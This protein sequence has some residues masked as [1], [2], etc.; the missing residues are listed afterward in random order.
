MGAFLFALFA[1][2]TLLVAAP[3]A[4]HA[5]T[6][7][8]AVLTNSSYVSAVNGSFGVT[9]YGGDAG[10]LAV[11]SQGDLFYIDEPYGYPNSPFIVEI[12][13]NGGAPFEVLVNL[14][15][16][17]NGITIDSQGN[18]WA[19]DQAG[20][21]DF[22]PYINGAFA[23]LG[24]DASTLTSC[25]L[26]MSTNTAPCTFPWNISTLGYYVQPNDIAIDAAG[27][28]YVY[29]KY[30]GQSQGQ[31]NRILVYSPVDGSLTYIVDGIPPDN[32]NAQIAVDSAGDSFM[33]NQTNVYETLASD[34][35]HTP[36]IIGSGLSSPSGVGVDAKNNLYITD[37]GNNRIVVIPQ[38]G[39]TYS[40]SNQYM[41]AETPNANNGPAIDGF[42]NVY[43]VGQY[44]NS[45]NKQS[46]GTVRF[47]ASAVGSPNTYAMNVAFNSSVT[48][49]SFTVL[50]SGAFSVSASQP[51]TGAC[52][53]GAY[54]AGQYCQVNVTYN[55]TAAG[56]Q[57]AE[58][59]AL[60]SSNAVLGTMALSGVGQAATLN[61]D[62]GTLSAIG[63]NWSAPSSVAVD[64]FG[65][66]YVTDSA[67]GK[68]YK[69]PGSGG[70][71]G[72]IVS[73]L[74]SPSAIVVDGGGN[75]YVAESTG[76]Y[77][78]ANNNG[79]YG[80]PSQIASGTS[81]KTGLAIDSAGVLYVADSGNS[82]VLRISPVY[83]GIPSQ[84]LVSGTFTA[85]VAVAVDGY[86]NVFVVDSG[87][88][89]EVAEGAS[90]ATTVTTG[91]SNGAGIGVDASGSLYVL[92]SGAK[93][94]TRIPS[95]NG[96]LT[97]ASKYTLG[98]L[99][100]SPS[101]MALDGA[102]DV[103]IVDTTDKSV[104]LL[105]RSTGSLAFASTN[106]GSTSGD[107]TAT[108]SDG[109]NQALVFNTPAFTGTTA[110][111]NLLDS[112]TCASGGTVNAGSTCSIVADF[113]PTA[114]GATSSTLTFSAN[115]AN[116]SSLVLAGTGVSTQATTTTTVTG[117]PNP[118]TIGQSVTL[119]ATVTSGSGTPSGTVTFYYGTLEL[120]SA[121]LSSGTG[122]ITASSAGLPAGSY[123]ITADYAGN[124]SYKASSGTTSVTLSSKTNTTTTV[125][126]T[127]NPATPGQTVT[128]KATISSSSCTGSVSFYSGST[129]IATADVS[130]GSAS[131]GASTT[132]LPAG[133]YPVTANYSG[134]TS[135]AASSG[136]TSVTL[137]NAAATTTTVTATPNPATPGQTITLKATVT[138]GSGTPNG[139][140]VS[141]YSGTT[142]IGSATVSN[143]TASY[144]ASSTGLPAGTYPVTA[145]YGGNTSYKASSGSTNVT[146]N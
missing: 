116:A 67:A 22:V 64:A 121:T 96:T 79:S 25:T 75:L 108:V 78:I 99:P 102:G 129:F 51:S 95:I 85:P 59:V 88:V 60:G 49:S 7:P 143:G 136:S 94:I 70:A 19:A 118:A 73:G 109:G 30:D 91:L 28:V 138:S 74:S 6:A 54:T 104:S 62:P 61:V 141:F 14:G 57:S 93:T 126:A 35:T 31:Y 103:Y 10:H 39:G 114:S 113:E 98:N 144:A 84:T 92:D 135:C 97:P 23:G 21:I 83:V 134:S 127:P 82:R 20:R 44:G 137:S 12:P 90:S 128:L 1:A 115:A 112:T 47:A 50:G 146:L 66:T 72:A 16:N 17:S 130:G 52:T 122:S 32:G 55:P 9:D 110:P 8:S 42:G 36:F 77:F 24:T 18:L 142:F 107:L 33:A 100:A 71:Q 27:N 111:F 41:L 3:V 38:I 133:T 123:T 5:Q 53:A 81:G 29:D 106:V 4:A 11:D 139:G 15:S 43:Y 145:N 120:G 131:Y 26:P 76:V 87:N 58:L 80:T 2:V 117:T 132:G 119:K 89:L 56:P 63:S 13:I 69:T 140:T 124:S 125:A 48:L 34:S 45:I 105:N 68:I 65:N 46:I 86:N 40:T 37:T 101:A